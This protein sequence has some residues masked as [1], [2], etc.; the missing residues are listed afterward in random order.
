MPPAPVTPA[1]CRI[2]SRPPRAGAPLS[3]DPAAT[4]AR[5]PAARPRRG[6]VET[7]R[8]AGQAAAA[9]TRQG[10]P[11]AQAASALPMARHG[12][13]GE[14]HDPH[15]GRSSGARHDVEPLTV[16]WGSGRRAAEQV[17]EYRC[18]RRPERGSLGRFSSPRRRELTGWRSATVRAAQSPTSSWAGGGSAATVSAHPARRAGGARGRP[19][20]QQL[21]VH[22]GH[23]KPGHDEPARYMCTNSMPEVRVEQRGPR[24]IHHLAALDAKAVVGGSSAVDR[25]SP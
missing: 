21:G 12:A 3:G 22:R 10:E 18:G 19:F 4:S 6:A 17:R 9:P 25:D 1:R 16:A 20:S 8:W 2:T 14:L 15:R 11:P 23:R 7:T 13:E 5:G 24:S